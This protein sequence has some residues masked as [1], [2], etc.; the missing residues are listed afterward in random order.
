[1][2][3]PAWADLTNNI[4]YVEATKKN[5][6]VMGVANKAPSKK[7]GRPFAVIARCETYRRTGHRGTRES[8]VSGGAL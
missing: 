8:E 4:N 2:E 7:L 3:G 1:V 6:D 5:D